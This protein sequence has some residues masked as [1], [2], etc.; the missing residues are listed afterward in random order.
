VAVGVAGT[1]LTGTAPIV[2]IEG[3]GT[4]DLQLFLIAQGL[5]EMYFWYLAQAN[6]VSAD[7]TVVAGFGYNP[8]NKMEGFI[9]D[10]KKL[11]V[12]H[13]PSGNPENART[14]GIELGSAADHVAHG[15]LPRDLRV[16]ELGRALARRRDAPEP[17]EPARRGEQRDDRYR[18]R[19]RRGDAV[20]HRSH[21][22][23][24]HSR[25]RE[26]RAQQE[27]ASPGLSLAA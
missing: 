9:V 19:E 24:R 8:D 13:M 27:P 22:A 1:R 25:R 20:G 17:R 6:A 18:R 3:V 15:E 2:W 23:R 12:C 21:P 5:D 14:L 26:G 10:M 16:H 11:W 7:G 4:I